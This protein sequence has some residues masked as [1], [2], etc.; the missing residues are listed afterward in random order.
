VYAGLSGE[1][2]ARRGRRLTNSIGLP[3]A[4]WCLRVQS[5]CRTSVNVQIVA[6]PEILLAGWLWLSEVISKAERRGRSRLT[7][8]PNV[9]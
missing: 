3:S 2:A 9:L 4:G 1:V 6:V 7:I 8:S 5:G